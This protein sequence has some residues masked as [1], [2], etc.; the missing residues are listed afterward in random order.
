LVATHMKAYVPH[1]TL[2]IGTSDINDDIDVGIRPWL[3]FY[4]EVCALRARAR[5]NV[6]RRSETELRV[7]RHCR[8]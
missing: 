1:R 3:R 7:Q 4:A 8:K 2:M 5:S 6:T